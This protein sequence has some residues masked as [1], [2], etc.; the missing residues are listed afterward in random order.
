MRFERY[1]PRGRL[2][3]HVRF[4]WA[5]EQPPQRHPQE[6]LLPTGEMGL[7]V[8]VSDP[9]RSPP[10]LAG[11]SSRPRVLDTARS[12]RLLGVSFAPGG[13]SS[14]FRTDVSEIAN[15][16]VPLDE[17]CG[18]SALA[19]QAEILEAA[20]NAVRFRVLERYLEVLLA[21][22]DTPGHPAVRYALGE[23]RSVREVRIADLISRLGIGQRRFIEMFRSEVG[24]TPK[25]YQ[26]VARFQQLLA[27]IEDHRDVHWSDVASLHGY[28]D[29][30]HLIHDFN[31]LAGVSPT[32]YLRHRSS[33]NHVTLPA[34]TSGNFLQSSARGFRHDTPR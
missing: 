14:L 9:S 33:R 11:A 8:D 17:F 23:L 7:F 5:S 18:R 3:R 30:A 25:L 32:V 22:A 6:R 20:T 31:V 16:T 26:R 4:L 19:L 13:A 15:L 34:S 1:V 27:S 24:L 12:I 28:F 2:S 10:I 29:Q 21:A